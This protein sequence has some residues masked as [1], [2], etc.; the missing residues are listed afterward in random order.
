MGELIGIDGTEPPKEIDD[1]LI[2][3]LEGMLEAAK[4]GEISSLVGVYLD[5]EGTNIE[6]TCVDPSEE[7]AMFGALNK[8][9]LTYNDEHLTEYTY[10]E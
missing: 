10:D 7:Y 9:V 8:L 4:N 2:K 3:L 6:F 5:D 1:S